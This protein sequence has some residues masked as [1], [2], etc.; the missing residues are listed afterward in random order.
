MHIA[1]VAYTCTHSYLYIHTLNTYQN[2]LQLL[3]NARYY[4]LITQFKFL[5]ACISQKSLDDMYRYILYLS[6]VYATSCSCMC[7]SM[8]AYV[9]VCAC[10][11]AIFVAKQ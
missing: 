8:H 2:P 3:N 5:N 4:V 10:V 9:C 11:R 1:R 7:M 6:L